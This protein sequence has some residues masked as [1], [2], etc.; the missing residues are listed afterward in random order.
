M[1]KIRVLSD[2]VQVLKG[3]G[4]TS[5][6]PYELHIQTGYAYTVDGDGAVAEIPEK[7]E[8]I[9]GDDGQGG[10]AR[11]MP[12]GD[13]VLSPSAVYVDRS[14]RMAINPRFVAAASAK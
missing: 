3:V 4:K 1:I 13:Y 11:P 7:F 9:L 12:R 10:I 6:K 8:F 2:K 5:G 14:G